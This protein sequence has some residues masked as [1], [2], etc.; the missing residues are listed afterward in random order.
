MK[1]TIYICSLVM[2]TLMSCDNFLDLEPQ[3]ALTSTG[4]YQTSQDAITAVNAA[5]DGFQTLNYY[6]FNYPMILNIAAGDALKGGFGAGDRGQYFEYVDF[7]FTE[8]NPWNQDFYKSAW[9]S[10]NRA[11]LVLENVGAM[12]VGPAFSQ[13]LKT[14]VLGEATFLR[15]LHYYNL[16]LGYGGMPIYT[17]VPK[18]ES[19]PLPRATAADTWAFII[20]DFK[21]AVTMLPDTY[22][23]S[24]LG[25][26][27]SGA[28]NAMLAR[29]SALQ[30]KWDD[31]LTYVGVVENSPANYDITSD[32]GTNFDGTGNNNV[33]SIF[34]V[35]YTLSSTSLNVWSSAGDW[36]S[37]AFSRYSAPQLENGGW[38]FM[39]PTQELVDD[40]ESGDLRLGATVYQPGDA[41]GSGIFDPSAG[42]H[43][44]NAGD[45]GLKKYTDV[46]DG[47]NGLGFAI[48]YKII[49]Y[50]EIL[51][52][53]AEAENE[54]DGPTT[55]A[56]NPLNR[57]RLRASLADVDATNNPGLDKDM[58][59]DIIM[60]ER[61][62]ELAYEGV[63]YYD[64][65]YRNKASEVFGP[66]GF[67]TGKDELFPIPAV[68]IEET[69]WDQN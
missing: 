20:Q 32:Y 48:N 7:G 19:D 30:G 38:G 6:G 46:G 52:L 53:K 26:A 39:S 69:G 24:N 28:A 16:V 9:G 17:T 21:D 66:R 58:L 42:T 31:V 3:D 60:H 65:I 51:L 36:N 61:R 13:E 49:R 2:L 63:R 43:A 50:G 34:E 55:A 37:N 23:S 15:A 54:L 12:E 5:Y 33:E 27:T 41:Y 44:G 68:E 57:I 40:Y 67:E 4:F 47:T 22:D 45:F 62:I 35:Q 25:R 14:R 10:I 29:I 18:I 1:K 64:V 59:R 56:L 11:N 8:G